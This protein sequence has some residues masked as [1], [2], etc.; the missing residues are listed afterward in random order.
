MKKKF[1]TIDY[2]RLEELERW[3]AIEY[4]RRLRTIN[5]YKFW[6][7]KPPETRY[8]LEKEAYEKEQELRKLKGLEPL[9]ELKMTKIL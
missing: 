1:S 7:F 2:N 6:G 5:Q 9:P 8:D 4:P 3:R